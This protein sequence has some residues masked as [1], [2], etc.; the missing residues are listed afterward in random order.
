M[1]IRFGHVVDVKKKFYVLY[2]TA[3]ILYIIIMFAAPTGW[4]EKYKIEGEKKGNIYT[5]L[6]QRH[7]GLITCGV[8]EIRRRQW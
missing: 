4:K 5:S 6:V 1:R 2:S 8:G 3:S 7:V